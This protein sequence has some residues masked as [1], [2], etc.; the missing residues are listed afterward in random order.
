MMYATVVKAVGEKW[1]DTPPQYKNLSD[2]GQMEWHLAEELRILTKDLKELAD[3]ADKP[4]YP[5][6]A[7]CSCDSKITA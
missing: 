3:L 1:K 5:F 7:S 4:F 6:I 2:T